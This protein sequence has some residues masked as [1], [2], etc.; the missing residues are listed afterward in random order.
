MSTI[1]RGTTDVTR[2]VM[3]VDASD[4]SPETG[5]T[6]TNFDLQ[7]TRAG[8]APASKVDA[9]ALGATNSV[10]ADNKMF[11][12]DATSSPGLYRIDWPDAA[13]AVGAGSVI[14]AVTSSDSFAPAVEDITLS[15]PIEFSTGAAISTPPKAATAGFV[16]TWGENEAN[17]EDSTHALD[18]TT[19]DIEAQNDTTEKI[20]VYYEFTVG[21]DGITTGV[22]AHHQ[23]D[24]GGGTGKNLQVYAYNWGGTSWDQI[25]TLESSTS[26]ETDDY[27]LFAAHVGTGANLGLVRIRYETGSVAFST[28][29]KLLV[30][31][32]LV[33]YTVVSRTVGYAN[34]SIWIN[35]NASNTNTED[36]VDGTADN[37]VSTIA[38]AL[39]ISA[40][41]GLTDFHIINGSSIT[42]PA[43]ADKHSF[44]GDNWTLV[45]NGQSVVSIHVEGATVSGAMAGTGADQSFR[46]CQMGACSLIADTHLESCRITGTQTL[47]EAGDIF[48]EDCHSGVSGSTAPILDFG[49]AIGNSNVHI[50]DYSGGIQLENMGDAGTDTLNFEGIGQLI[51]GT[52][53]SGTVTIRGIVSVS[54]ITNLTVT[55]VARLDIDQVADNAGRIFNG[56]STASSTALEVFVQA[57]DPPTGAAD[58]DYAGSLIVVYDGTDKSTARLNVRVIESYKDSD[59]K[60]SVTPALGFTP[61]AGD[62]VE[63]F[64][65]DSAALDLLTTLSSGFGSASPDRLIDHLRAVMSKDA[66]APSTG[67]GTYLP[68]RG[69]LEYL[70][71]TLVSQQGAG[72][73]T[74][75]D[76]L[77]EIRDAID[78]LVAPSVVSS[79]A[80]SGSGFLSD[81]VSLIRKAVDEPSLTPKYTDSD[82]VELLQVAFDTVLT[83]IHVSTDH[84]VIIRHSVTLA[85]GE[86]DYIMPVGVG[87]LLRIAKIN[88]G[89][90]LP[91]WEAWP[92]SYFNPGGHGWKIEG[93]VLRLLRDW[94]STD[95]LELMYIPN[96]EPLFHKAS[97][98]TPATDLDNTAL[99]MILNATVTDGTL[100]TRE[101]AYVGYLIRVISSNANTQ[102]ERLI[103]AYNADT[104]VA[105]YNKA[106]TRTHEGASAVTYEIVPLFSRLIKHVVCLRT[107]IDILSQEGNAKRMQTLTANY[108]IKLA[109]MRRAISKKEGRFPHHFDGDTWD[110]T[111]RGGSFGE[112]L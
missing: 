75:T 70:G 23:L 42:L 28:T 97:L 71:D 22:K 81:C 55:E 96:A 80:L 46:N 84:P 27:T 20:D 76:S 77:K 47:I 16:I 83:D 72:F 93:N 1:H 36:F 104:R 17:D 62:L 38:A 66:T 18:G 54:G 33:E 90:N 69:A 15:I 34:G 45:L 30:D 95:T 94:Q 35:T 107:S 57:T 79:S 102:E 109:A 82:I 111:N 13:F 31:Q 25:G 108:Q 100:D 14:L 19:H 56:T 10:H 74:G 67:V 86:Q 21:G 43:T 85:S 60:F 105:T 98:A 50:R 5:A 2:Y 103:T 52:C 51:E 37:P 92:G 91:E 87:E 59:P 99:T 40:S 44:F 39:T 29:T 41:L 3:I 64:R 58:E 4:G 53:T 11:E 6:I 88:T 65:A 73:A 32:I 9:T 106:F 8:E 112:L 7:Y 89:T 24:K 78:V 61:G 49:G 63:V 101:N 48:F 12:V 26:L 110:N 68:A